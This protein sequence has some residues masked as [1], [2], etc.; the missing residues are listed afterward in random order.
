[1]RVLQPDISLVIPGHDPL[2]F[3]KFPKVAEDVVRIR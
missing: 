1:M 3:L 2:V